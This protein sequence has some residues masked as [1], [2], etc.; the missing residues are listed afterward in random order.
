MGGSSFKSQQGQKRLSIK[1]KKDISF[2]NLQPFFSSFETPFQCNSLIHQASTKKNRT[3]SYVKHF[4]SK[5]K[6][7][8]IFLFYFNKYYAFLTVVNTNYLSLV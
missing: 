3:A 2:N 7:F 4:P 6:N 5:T 1:K 8:C